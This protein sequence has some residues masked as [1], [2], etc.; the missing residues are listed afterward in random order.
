MAEITPPP[1]GSAADVPKESA[2]TILFQFVVFPLGVVLIGVLIFLLFGM[3]ASERHTVPD[4]LNEIQSGSS[5]ER[6]QAAYQLSRSIERGEAKKY[7]NL[8]AD[9]G[10]LY[11]ASKNDDPRIR[12]YL[13]MVLGKL[14]DRRMMPVLVEGLKDKDVDNHV[15][16]LL[17]LGELGDPR[18]VPALLPEL[19]SGEK[20]V[21]KTAAYALGQI[22]DPAAVPALADAMSD[23][24]ADVRFNTALALARFNDRRSLPG[25]H[26]MLDRPH[27][28]RLPG[29]RDDQK[30]DAMIVAMGPYEKLV[31]REALPDLQKLAQSDKSLRVRAAAAEAV[32]RAR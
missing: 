21:R 1:S 22:G 14:G 30:E 20:D 10:R 7:P 32:R 2:R 26:E 19:K 27:L 31:G 28:D 24:V 11:T 3:L 6:W 12:R 17:A 23:P 29:M 9:V 8:P 16:A 5:H 25:L 13:S 4:Y 18:A 15:Y